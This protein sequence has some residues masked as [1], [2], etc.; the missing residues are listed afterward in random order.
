[1]AIFTRGEVSV[2]FRDPLKRSRPQGPPRQAVGFSGGGVMKVV[3][4][5]DPDEIMTLV[6]DRLDA[7][8]GEDLRDFIRDT[9]R[10][11]AYTFSYTDPFAVTHTNMRYDSGYDTFDQGGPG[12][13]WSATLVIRK[14]LG[15]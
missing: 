3:E 12:G 9:I 8:D 5:G 15:A 11:H 4:T 7:D 6:L 13:R 10:Y 14:D 1:M 2:T